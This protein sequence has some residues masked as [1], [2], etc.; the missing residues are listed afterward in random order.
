V[1]SV[2]DKLTSGSIPEGERGL[3]ELKA[4]GIKTI[5]SVDGAT[6]DV[7]AAR[8]RGMRYVHIPI[9]YHGIDKERQLEL[10]R[11]V[12][13]LPGPIYL[14]CHHGKHRGPAAAA[15]AAVVLGNLTPEEGDALLR[16]AGTAA[17]YKGLYKCVNDAKPATAA[18]L[19]RVPADFPEVAPIPEFVKAMAAVQDAYDHLVLIRDSGWVTPQN[20]PDLVPLD[21]ASRLAGLMR[22]LRKDPELG[23]HPAE[24]ATMFLESIELTEQFERAVR[25]QAPTMDRALLLSQIGASCRDC[26][27]KY[28]DQR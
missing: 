13:D 2:T 6:P 4:M 5:I 25:S 18:D 17:G 19:D 26:H 16:Q 7:E 8:A 24:F 20:H 1:I 3:E 14:H 15:S 28:R 12:R 10:A 11:A 21:E 22:G 9:G 27:V 23:R